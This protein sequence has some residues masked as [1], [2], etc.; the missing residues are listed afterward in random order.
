VPKDIDW[1]PPQIDDEP[2]EYG[3]KPTSMVEI[4]PEMVFSIAMGLEDPTQI[5][6][7]HGI[8]GEKWQALQNWKPFQ[9]AVSAQR[10]EFEKSGVTFR[11]KSAMKADML[12]DKLFVDAMSH[13]T[14]ILQRLEVLKTFA[15][16]GNLEP[17]EDKTAANAPTFAISID[18]GDRSIQLNTTPKPIEIPAEIREI[19]DK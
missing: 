10:A 3:W 13:E 14:T 4:P 5:A 2:L 17:K 19:E 11:L 7:R 18:L 9:L 16:L 1:V 12:A 8:T 6:E 15:K